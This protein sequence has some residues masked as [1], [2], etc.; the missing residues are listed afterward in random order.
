MKGHVIIFISYVKLFLKCFMKLMLSR[1][2]P[3][4]NG[5]RF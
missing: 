5:C 2:S 1:A 3:C 4:R